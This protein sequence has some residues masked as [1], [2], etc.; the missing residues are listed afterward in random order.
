MK[1]YRQIV[2]V[3]YNK[4]V[5]NELIK[6]SID[7]AYIKHDKDKQEPHYHFYSKF[8]SPKSTTTIG[9]ICK[10]LKEKFNEN[11]FFE[12]LKSNE[13]INYFLHIKDKNKYQYNL[14]DIKSNIKDLVINKETLNE[15]NTKTLAE[16]AICEIDKG[17]P[18]PVIIRKNP[19]LLYS[20][21]NLIKYRELVSMEYTPIYSKASQ[22]V[23][24]MIFEARKNE[25]AHFIQ[26]QENKA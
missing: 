26:N 22:L 14:N 13:L 20:I 17:I 21:G 23:A 4:Q 9:N 11:I 1:Q 19:K 15:Q 24:D 8:K 6:L 16:I 5:I 3:F 7:Y 12:P 25:D 2:F 10:K 18:I